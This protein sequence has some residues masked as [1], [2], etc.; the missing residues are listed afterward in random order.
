MPSVT[1]TLD[2][3]YTIYNTNFRYL[4]T[5]ADSRSYSQQYKKSTR[6][7][8]I[9]WISAYKV[10]EKISIGQQTGFDEAKWYIDA[11]NNDINTHVDDIN[12]HVDDIN[13]PVFEPIDDSVFWALMRRVGCCD[14]D[15]GR[16][17]KCCISLSPD[18]CRTVLYMIN[19][20]FLPALKTALTDIP[21]MDGINVS[22]YND[23]LTHIIAKGPEFYDG[24]IANPIVSLYLC[25][26]FYP[27]YTWLSQLAN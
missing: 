8:N 5:T 16:M 1:K 26:Q 22:E 3:K 24:M 21:I 13:T 19:G 17:T 6:F 2:G 7:V 11:K 9:C 10:I 18:D 4:S 12:T 15:E 25:D 20:K 14:K 27:V 23:L